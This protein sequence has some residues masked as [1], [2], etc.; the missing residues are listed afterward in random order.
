MNDPLGHLKMNSLCNSTTIIILTSCI[1][2]EAK[3][4]CSSE[5]SE[6]DSSAKL[7]AKGAVAATAKHGDVT[8]LGELPG[9]VFCDP[10]SITNIT[11]SSR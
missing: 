3:F 8:V 1:H 9:G 10:K 6:T 2:S 11:S 7:E 4:L 5:I